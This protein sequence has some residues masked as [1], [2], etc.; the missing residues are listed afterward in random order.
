MKNDSGTGFSFPTLSCQAC[1][2]RPSCGS[3]LSFNQ[4][5]LEIVPHINFCKNNPEPSLASIKL[6]PFLEQIFQ[7]VP[8]ASPK[9]HTYCVAEARQSVLS[10]VLLEL[11]ELHNVKR[12]SSETLADISRPIA[13]YYSSISPATSAAS[14]CDLPTSTAVCFPLTSILTL[15]MFHAFRPTMAAVVRAPQT[16]L[17][18]NLRSISAHSEGHSFHR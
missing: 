16:F 5:D 14:S 18:R 7:H 3:T 1:L 13:Q 6:T 11:A 10:S 4:G 17:P 8:Q 12:M 2:V 15:C 9:F